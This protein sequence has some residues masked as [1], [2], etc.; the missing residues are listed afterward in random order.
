[1]KKIF[2]IFLKLILFDFLVKALFLS[3]MG[4]RD[5]SGGELS[6]TIG[7]FFFIE[8]FFF[9]IPYFLMVW[10]FL[11]IRK[12]IIRYNLNQSVICLLSIAY[13]TGIATFIF[14]TLFLNEW[15]D[16]QV[17]AFF[18]NSVLIGIALFWITRKDSTSSQSNS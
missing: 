9:G 11:V 10:L 2:S 14:L 6:S 4:G 12:S 15:P 3:L 5:L 1:M 18:G 16:F 8:I 13:V 17:L 7:Y